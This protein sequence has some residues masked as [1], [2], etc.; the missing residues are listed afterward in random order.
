MIREIHLQNFR[1]HE[2]LRL[3][4]VH[5]NLNVIIGDTGTGKTSIFRAMKLLFNNKPS[6]GSKL[7]KFKESSKL[8]IKALIDDIV[9]TRE[10]KKYILKYIDLD[11]PLELT[12]FGKNVPEPIKKVINI[13]DINWQLQIQPHF[14]ILDN[15]GSVSKYLNPIFGSE[16]NEQIILEIK[17]QSSKVKEQIRLHN[18]IIKNNEKILTQFHNITSHVKRAEKIQSHIKHL[19]AT[20]RLIFSIQKNL[21]SI[22]KID[23]QIK[24]TEKIEYLVDKLTNIDSLD[25]KA[26]KLELKINKI[27]YYINKIEKIEIIPVDSFLNKI[28]VIEDIENKKSS[29][30]DRIFRIQLMLK[31]YDNIE[32]NIEE[33]TI[34]L[35]KDKK[36]WDE[37][38]NS[39]DICPLCDQIIRKK[40]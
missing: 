25:S 3:K 5:P 38:F 39:L 36:E 19:Q 12:S 29:L 7:Y 40:G 4:N 14:L 17:N 35:N 2:K 22:Q 20:E 26:T 28:K 30:Q 21:D 18:S 6:G 8:I 37:T 32:E 24:D 15:G 1:P 9:I 34:E 23:E 13:Q 10:A 11:K 31:S 33:N 27:E 16:E